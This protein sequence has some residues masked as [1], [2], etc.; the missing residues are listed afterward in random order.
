[1]PTKKPT[2]AQVA[3]RKKFATMAKDGTL[4]KKR[5]AATKKKTGLSKPA[6]K[7]TTNC[8]TTNEANLKLRRIALTPCGRLRKGWKFLKCGLLKFVG[9]AKKVVKKK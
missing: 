2:P 6:K 5:K 8:I 3:A 1:M 4:A 7:K 9:T